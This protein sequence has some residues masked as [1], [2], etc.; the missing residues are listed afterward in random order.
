MNDNG[1]LF[2]ARI[3]THLQ[4]D[5]RIFIK[6]TGHA[7]ASEALAILD[8]AGVDAKR[9]KPLNA[10]KPG[11]RRL[12]FVCPAWRMSRMTPRH[13]TPFQ[14]LPMHSNTLECSNRCVGSNASRYIPIYSNRDRFWAGRAQL[15][16]T[17]TPSAYANKQGEA[18]NTLCLSGLRDQET[19]EMVIEKFVPDK[20]NWQPAGTNP[21]T[22]KFAKFAQAP[23]P[24]SLNPS[25]PKYSRPRQSKII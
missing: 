23:A 18:K 8:E 6:F 11:H 21:H 3:K 22:G 2:T 14:Y 1:F 15:H 17:F 20:W 13:S 19:E 9:S 4:E 12:R 5:S 25:K 10:Q 24:I 7:K 16:D